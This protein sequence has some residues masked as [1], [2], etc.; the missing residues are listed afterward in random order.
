MRQQLRLWLVVGLV[1]AGL[2]GGLYLANREGVAA[3]VTPAVG[4]LA[5]WVRWSRVA[6][7]RFPLIFMRLY[8]HHSDDPGVWDA[9]FRMHVDSEREPRYFHTRLGD[10]LPG[11]E[12]KLVDVH[13]RQPAVED[14]LGENDDGSTV[15]LASPTRRLTLSKDQQV[16]DADGATVYELVFFPETPVRT[17]ASA[18][19]C[20]VNGELRLAYA[21]RRES[22]RL[23]LDAAGQPVLQPQRDGQPAGTPVPVPPYRE[24]EHV[25]WTQTHPRTE[26]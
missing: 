3:P 21:G 5:E 14:K 25:R 15:T 26:D 19:Q 8:R 23:Q 10:T 2:V 22:Y 6:P 9:I 12:F 7:A 20:R 4:P 18:Y 1:L 11:T 17:L 24:A 13:W 16:E